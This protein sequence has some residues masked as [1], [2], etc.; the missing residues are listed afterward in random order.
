MR[1]APDPPVIARLKELTSLSDS[2]IAQVAKAG[3][4]V[5]LPESWAVIWEKT[6]A[7]AAYYILEGEV[8][9]RRGGKEIATLGAGDFLGEVAILTHRLRTAAVV[10]KTR[11]K[12]LHFTAEHG[13]ALAANIPRIGEALRATSASRLEAEKLG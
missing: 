10:T 8:S 2:E 11:V 3:Q 12:A 6:P 9:I 7:D 5:N 4:L 1:N 13:Q